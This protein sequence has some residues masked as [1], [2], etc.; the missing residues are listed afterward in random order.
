MTTASPISRSSACFF[1][2]AVTFIAW[3]SYCA[4]RLGLE[5]GALRAALAHYQAAPPASP[6][7]TFALAYGGFSW[8]LPVASLVLLVVAKVAGW[9]DTAKGIALAAMA[10]AAVVAQVAL[11]EGVYAPVV[12]FINKVL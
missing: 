5:V 8:L 10:A 1:I 3:Q 12:W 2:A 6:W 11:T 7:E 4:L 9:S